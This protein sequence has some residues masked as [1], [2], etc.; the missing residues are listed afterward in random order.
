MFK[1]MKRWLKNTYSGSI[2]T[3]LIS[4]YTFV[5]IIVFSSNL[6]SVNITG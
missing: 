4:I 6:A 1:G 5:V 3:K 2:K